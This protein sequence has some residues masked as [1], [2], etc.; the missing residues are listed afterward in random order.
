MKK[1]IKYGIIG[2]VLL[3]LILYIS[4]ENGYYERL[5]QEKIENMDTPL[6]SMEIKSVIIILLTK[7]QRKA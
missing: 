7:L 5:N 4:Y 1:S 6:G 2:I 3:Y